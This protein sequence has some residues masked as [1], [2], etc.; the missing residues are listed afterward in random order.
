MKSAFLSLFVLHITIPLVSHD[1]DTTMN[2][3]HPIVS[4]CGVQAIALTCIDHGGSSD[5][6]HN[7][8]HPSVRLPYIRYLRRYGIRQSVFKRKEGSAKTCG[9]ATARR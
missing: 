2:I 4:D 1:Y 8:I 5:M 3:Y 6:G 9:R 7:S